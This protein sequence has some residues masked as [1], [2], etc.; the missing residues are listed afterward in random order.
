MVLSTQL[1]QKFNTVLGPLRQVQVLSDRRGTLSYRLET[2]SD[3]RR[4]SRTGAGPLRSVQV[5][6]DR[7]AALS[8]QRRQCVLRIPARWRG[9]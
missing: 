8:N 2:L 3:R 9:W 4:S 6:S 7:P 5:L 1:R